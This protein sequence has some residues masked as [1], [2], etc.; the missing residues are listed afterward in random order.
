MKCLARSGASFDD[1]PNARLQSAPSTTITAGPEPDTS[2]AI[3]VPSFDSTCPM[4]TSRYMSNGACG[5]DKFI[6]GSKT[7]P[8]RP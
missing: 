3:L 1:G 8:N 2:Y 4:T 6:V 5:I 7:K